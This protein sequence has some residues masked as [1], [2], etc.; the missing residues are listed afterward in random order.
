MSVQLPRERGPLRWVKGVDDKTVNS[1]PPYDI[2]R[3][4]K[5]RKKGVIFYNLSKRG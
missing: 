3:S 1:R 5:R 2:M 4:E